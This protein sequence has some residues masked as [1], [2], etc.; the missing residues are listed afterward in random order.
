MKTEFENVLG[1]GMIVVLGLPKD[2]NCA[3][4]DHHVLL[5]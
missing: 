5:G 4:D 2:W 3:C 1:F